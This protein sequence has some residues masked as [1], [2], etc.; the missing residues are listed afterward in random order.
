MTGNKRQSMVQ[1]MLGVETKLKAQVALLEVKLN[2]AQNKI[3]QEN[4][5]EVSKM[6]GESNNI[7]ALQDQIGNLN[8]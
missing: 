5:G 3:M 6:N 2:Q 7:T 8:Q 1:H 4:A